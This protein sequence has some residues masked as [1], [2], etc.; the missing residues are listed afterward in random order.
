[1]SDPEDTE[2]DAAAT[3]NQSDITETPQELDG[4]EDRLIQQEVLDENVE[5]KK[6]GNPHENEEQK[7]QTIPN[8][9]ERQKEQGAPEENGLPM[10]LDNIGDDVSLSSEES[11]LSDNIRSKVPRINCPE[12]IVS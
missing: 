6:Q 7:V 3:G 1:M 4:P 5:Q 2:K 11:S 9:H 8:E 12:K 10:S